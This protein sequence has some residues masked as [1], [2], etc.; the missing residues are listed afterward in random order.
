MAAADR[1]RRSSRSCSLLTAWEPTRV[2]LQTA[3]ML[4]NMLGSGP[5]VLG[6]LTPKP[7]RSA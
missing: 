4:P 7:H 6:L 2:A 5:Q 3:L 1:A